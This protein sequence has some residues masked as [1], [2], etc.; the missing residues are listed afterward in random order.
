MTK[1]HLLLIACVT[2]ALSSTT[3]GAATPPAAPTDSTATTQKKPIF[4][5]AKDHVKAHRRTYGATA[6]GVG[7]LS[8]LDMFRKRKNGKNYFQNEYGNNFLSRLAKLEGRA[9]GAALRGGVTATALGAGAYYALKGDG[10]QPA[11]G[12]G[13]NGSSGTSRNGTAN[14]DGT[15]AMWTKEEERPTY[16]DLREKIAALPDI[17][18]VTPQD[19]EKF[20]HAKLRL[21]KAR[22]AK[23]NA[24]LAASGSATEHDVLWGEDKTLSS[25]SILELI[26]ILAPHK[27]SSKEVQEFM[28]AV[29]QVGILDKALRNNFAKKMEALEAKAAELRLYE[30]E[31][32][33]KKVKKENPYDYSTRTDKAFELVKKPY[34][35]EEQ[36]LSAQLKQALE[37]Q[38]K[39]TY[40]AWKKHKPAQAREKSLQDKIDMLIAAKNRLVALRTASGKDELE[41]RKAQE[42]VRALSTQDVTAALAA[43]E[44]AL[45][46][47]QE[48]EGN[49]EDALANLENT[50]A[51]SVLDKYTAVLSDIERLE[52]AGFMSKQLANWKLEILGKI[53][54]QAGNNKY[55]AM[56]LEKWEQP[57]PGAQ[58]YHAKKLANDR[59][60]REG[61][62]SLRSLRDAR[63]ALKREYDSLA[64]N[65][66]YDDIYKEAESTY[67]RAFELFRKKKKRITDAGSV[68]TKPHENAI[69]EQR[70][71]AGTK[72]A[73]TNKIVEDARA[74]IAAIDKEKIKEINQIEETLPPHPRTVSDSVFRNTETI[75]QLE[76]IIQNQCKELGLDASAIQ[77]DD[78]LRKALWNNYVRLYRKLSAPEERKS[79]TGDED[80][81]TNKDHL[82]TNGPEFKQL[83][84]TQAALWELEELSAN[85]TPPSAA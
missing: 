18:S 35:E 69:E 27:E 63:Y 32:N 48:T 41:I 37:K 57:R 34:E 39:A 67:N 40:E 9:W 45:K 73:P 78:S 1:N 5:R 77:N 66:E 70:R 60:V 79:L 74:A 54:S 51:A 85:A 12:A 44:A 31:G 71:L 26:D 14:Q 7:T 8:L 56:Y 59:V 64:R 76:T 72:L 6:A 3:S 29:E 19:I 38:E 15:I 13:V 23:L 82:R 53:K 28:T 62:A 55:T 33:A 21:L 42:D 47:M 46:Q 16:A 25:K 83:Q 65:R 36:R 81:Y 84:R 52:E 68:R 58:H 4:I 20:A 49:F 2:V 11:A 43:Q 17:S 10:Q 75:R 50:P 61:E 24:R 30:E 80:L 22:R